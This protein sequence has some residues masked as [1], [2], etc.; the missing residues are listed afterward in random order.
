MN[1]YRPAEWKGVPKHQ[2]AMGAHRMLG[3]F[4]GGLALL[5]LGIAVFSGD[6]AWG[7]A[8]LALFIPA[9]FHGV[10]ALGAARANPV[11]Q[12]F[13]VLT[14]VLMLLGFPIGTVIG[15]Y[16]LR[17]ASWDRPV[18]APGADSAG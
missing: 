14:G 15:I 16:L 4:Y 8:M 6:A 5:V 10:I 3:I 18:V 7:P 13:S 9:A 11:A 12:V 17:N 1:G 2:K